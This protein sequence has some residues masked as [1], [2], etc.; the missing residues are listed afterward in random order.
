MKSCFNMYNV[1]VVFMDDTLKCVHNGTADT[2]DPS[3]PSGG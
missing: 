2:P 3:H 1:Q